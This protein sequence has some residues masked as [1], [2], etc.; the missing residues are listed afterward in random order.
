MMVQIGFGIIASVMMLSA[1]F[2][3]TS[4]NLVRTVLWLAVA[5]ASTSV[6]F[7]MLHAPFL[8]AIQLILYTGGVLTLMLFGIMLTQRHDGVEVPNESTAHARGLVTAAILF[9]VMAAAVL[10][11]DGTPASPRVD[12]SVEAI[13]QS[14]L[15]THLLAFEV[16]SI[17]LLAVMV[18]AIVL[19][20]PKDPLPPDEEAAQAG[21][22]RR[23]TT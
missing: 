3:V 7:V 19:A 14:F 15:T 4:R 1:L 12:I 5:L 23:H 2:V 22:V 10:R 16:L 9:G 20:R 18:G 17:L 21:P 13:G 11:T 6:A 8:A